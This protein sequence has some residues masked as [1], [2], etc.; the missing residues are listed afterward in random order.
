MTNA[1]E[2]SPSILPTGAD[3]AMATGSEDG[4]PGEQPDER[5]CARTSV[6]S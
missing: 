6:Q 5:P 2:S 1:D 3:T 4:D